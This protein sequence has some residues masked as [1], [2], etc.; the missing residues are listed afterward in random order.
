MPALNGP[1]DYD[2]WCNV[3]KKLPGAVQKYLTDWKD[4]FE[5]FHEEKPWLQVAELKETEKGC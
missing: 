4:S 2:D 5:L 1:K 3:P